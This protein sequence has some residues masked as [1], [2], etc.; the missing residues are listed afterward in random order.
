FKSFIDVLGSPAMPEHGTPVE[1]IV[2][3][4]TLLGA[5]RHKAVQRPFQR[6][7]KEVWEKRRDVRVGIPRVLNLYSTGPFWRTYFEMLGVDSRNVVF[8][9]ETSEEMWQAGCKYGS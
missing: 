3:K 9:D 7:S 2:V 1:D 6:A 5:V 4:K 8:S